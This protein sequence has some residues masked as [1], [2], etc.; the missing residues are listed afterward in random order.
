MGMISTIVLE[1]LYEQVNIELFAAYNYLNI[2]NAFLNLNYLGFA[3]WSRKQAF[4]EIDHAERI[5]KFIDDLDIPIKLFA[6]NEPMTVADKST[7]LALF[8]FALELEQNNT[9]SVND[10]YLLAVDHGELATAEMM[11]WFITEQVE[12]EAQL[13]NIIDDIEN[14]NGDKAG[15]LVLDRELGQRE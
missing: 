13:F 15:L 10:L 8:N 12:E 11:R 14:L 3:S 2:S 1:D 5:M 6:I 7:P 4:E 9:K